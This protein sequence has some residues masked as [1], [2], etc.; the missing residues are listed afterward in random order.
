MQPSASSLY[1]LSG[2]QENGFAVLSSAIAEETLL[3]IEDDYLQQLHVVAGK[4]SDLLQVDRNCRSFRDGLLNLSETP[5]LIPAALTEFDIMLPYNPFT[6][7][8]DDSP[9]YLPDSVFGLLTEGALLDSMQAVLGSEITAAPNQH[10]RLKF[11]VRDPS[12]AAY[13][14]KGRPGEALYRTTVWHQDAQTQMPQSRDSD[15]VTAWV[16]MQDADEGTGCLVVA[17]GYHRRPDLLPFPVPEAMIASLD[18]EAIALPVR[19]GDVVL[20]NKRTPHAS[21]ENRGMQIRW[22]FDFRYYTAGQVSSRPYFPSFLVRS[23]A[24]PSEVT[25]RASDWRAGWEA[26]RQHFARTGT[27]VPGPRD[28]AL[29]VA[30]GIADAWEAG[31]GYPPAPQPHVPAHTVRPQARQTV[32]PKLTGLR[33]RLDRD[34]YLVVPGVVDPARYLAPLEAEY[35][36]L[37][38]RLEAEWG[39]GRSKQDGPARA[40]G[41]FRSRLHDL[42]REP[43]FPREFLEQL[44]IT[45]PYSPFSVLH[46]DTPV[47]LG[48]AVY[49]LLTCP[50]VLDVVAALIGPEVCVSPD[51][52]YRA[53]LPQ[54]LLSPGRQSHEAKKAEALYKTTIWHQDVL[55]MMP[56]SWDTEFLTVW[57][58]MQ[59]VGLEDGPLLVVP[60]YHRHADRLLNFPAT[61]AQ[62]AEMEAAQV[63]LEV[64]A[65]DVVIL[66][67][68]MPHA[69][70]PIRSQGVRWSFD[71][72]YYPAGG[73]S[74]RPWFPSFLVRSSRDPGAVVGS[75]EE[76]ERAWLGARR[77]FADAGAPV[78]G[79]RVVTM[80][81]AASMASAWE[82]A[83]AL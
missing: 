3:R 45:L 73:Q 64:R 20:L 19:R 77:R 18:R 58:A 69:S 11:P 39:A 31:K 28:Y 21:L 53:K 32:E 49:N 36:E 74:N 24:H 26:T 27:L 35:S 78:P 83:Q 14:H 8:M 12:H 67:K 13:S 82:T 42:C 38:T 2:F 7:I 52:H 70:L 66:H 43:G 33:E 63:P 17:K 80:L 59:D 48:R 46:E 29:L 15:I 81:R 61:E 16:P 68:K 76:W 75:H 25:A 9:M 10:C 55:A 1:P 37:L 23:A 56:K 57:I 44:D 79:A 51:Q 50:E 47:H 72:R 65:G 62:V 40:A 34:G 22:S 41:P 71:F 60:G 5:D 54:D 6:R 30:S 4:R